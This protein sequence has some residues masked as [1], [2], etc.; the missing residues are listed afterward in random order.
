MDL[1]AS[2][3]EKEWQTFL[4]SKGLTEGGVARL[5]VLAQ[6]ELKEEFKAHK[7]GT[8]SVMK[9]AKS[10]AAM[11]PEEAPTDLASARRPSRLNL[12][13]S[14][15]FVRKPL[16]QQDE[17]EEII[18]PQVSPQGGG[19]QLQQGSREQSSSSSDKMV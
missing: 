13:R 5:P 18:S 10:L 2:A 8:E 12:G 1:S 19:V 7:N 4:D 17:D 9:K 16:S 11:S 14:A 6:M 3:Q 15:N